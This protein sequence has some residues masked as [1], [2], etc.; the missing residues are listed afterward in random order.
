MN[1]MTA[2]RM[3]LDLAVDDYTGLWEIA[4]GIEASHPNADMLTVV[5][6]AKRAVHSLLE[7]GYIEIYEGRKFNGDEH[8]ILQPDRRAVLATEAYWNPPLAADF[9]H[10]RVSATEAGEHAYE[11]GAV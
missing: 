2:E 1:G 10:V 8:R 9:A 6:L 11:T 5:E 7:K 3:V 4:W